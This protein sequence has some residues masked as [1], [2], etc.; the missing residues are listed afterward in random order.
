[1]AAGRAAIALQG[2]QQIAGPIPQL[3]GETTGYEVEK[4]TGDEVR[5]TTGYEVGETNGYEVGTTTGYEVGKTT[6]YEVGETAKALQ[7][8]QQIPGPHPQLV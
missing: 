1:M 3:V 7:G 8:R 2:C 6:G 5:K 4:T